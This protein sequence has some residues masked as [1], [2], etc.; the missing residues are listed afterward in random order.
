MTNGKAEIR[1]A[2]S[3]SEMLGELGPPGGRT[4]LRVGAGIRQPGRSIAG[5]S[6]R[7]EPWRAA[8]RGLWSLRV[9]RSGWS[10][11]LASLPL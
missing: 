7:G 5:W 6:L 1:E 2:C 4:G 11:W 10:E 8:E 9:D 3:S